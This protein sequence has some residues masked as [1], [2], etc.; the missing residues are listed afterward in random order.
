M[1]EVSKGLKPDAI[2]P[3]YAFARMNI[4]LLLLQYLAILILQELTL[5]Q[6]AAILLIL[7]P[8][9]A[10]ITL[11]TSMLLLQDSLPSNILKFLLQ[12]GRFLPHITFGTVL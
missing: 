9:L 10:L 11:I 5:L 1:S 2:A 7:I 8:K 3:D 12:C 4:V 6:G